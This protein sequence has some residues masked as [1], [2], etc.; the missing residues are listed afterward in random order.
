MLKTRKVNLMRLKRCVLSFLTEA[1]VRDQ[2]DV[3]W[4]CIAGM[5][6]GDGNQCDENFEEI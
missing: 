5:W 6:P 3:R 2:F 1:S 4:K